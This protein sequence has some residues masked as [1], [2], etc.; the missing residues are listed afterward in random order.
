MQQAI[1]MKSQI[2]LNELSSDETL[3]V[4]LEKLIVIKYM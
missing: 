3:F 4:A 2:L 1:Y